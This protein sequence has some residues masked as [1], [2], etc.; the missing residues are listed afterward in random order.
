MQLINRFQTYVVGANR[1]VG[2]FL[3]QMLANQDLPYTC[4]SFDS[5]EQLK[6]ESGSKSFL[7]LLPSIEE[8]ED[9]Q[10]IDFWLDQAQKL[11]MP[12][13]LLSSLVV[14]PAS[15]EAWQEE[16]QAYSE[17]LLAQEFLTIE[18]RARQNRR[19]IILRTGAV[20][21][22]MNKD[23]ASRLFSTMRTKEE[24]TLDSE[25]LF[26]PTPADDAANVVLAMLKQA[27]CMDSLWGTYHFNAVEPVASFQFAQA[28]FAEVS[29][30]EALGD[31]HLRSSE[32]GENPNVWIPS[33][34][35]TKLFHSFGIKPKAWRKGL[36]RLVKRYYQVKD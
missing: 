32:T 10:Y 23:F 9:F 2:Y 29:H 12:V 36:S 21:S 14:F 22:L 3:G 18:A 11:D 31:N 13:L 30:Y 8:K 35:N 6:A 34:D 7:V 25:T 17:H 5:K 27:N 26:N 19:H 16:D 4:F 20:F 24:L 28:L 1:P 15:Q 33:G